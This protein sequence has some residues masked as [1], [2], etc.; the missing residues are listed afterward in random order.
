MSK[1][2]ECSICY[3]VNHASKMQCSACG[4]I[5]S[6][7]SLTKKPVR[8]LSEDIGD[9]INGFVSVVNAVGVDRTERHR[10]C[11]RVLR[12]VAADYYADVE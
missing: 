4:T 11:K 2:Y 1:T 9:L 10:T 8:L 12:T 5:P 3:N 6:Q 7:Y